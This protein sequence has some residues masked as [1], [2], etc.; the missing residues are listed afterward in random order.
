M[1]ERR[2][3]DRLTVPSEDTCCRLSSARSQ[4]GPG[5][6]E[7]QEAAGNAQSLMEIAL[8]RGG[9]PPERCERSRGAEAEGKCLIAK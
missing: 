1:R 5:E 3:K 9:G 8:E 7:E 6:R 2:Q 4:G